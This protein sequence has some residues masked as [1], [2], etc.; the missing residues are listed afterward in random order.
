[1]EKCGIAR[2]ATDDSMIRRMRFACWIAE[3]TDAYIEY[4]ILTAFPRQQWLGESSSVLRLDVHSLS[5]CNVWTPV[6]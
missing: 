3:V 1:M 2:Q 6:S 5:C 4:T